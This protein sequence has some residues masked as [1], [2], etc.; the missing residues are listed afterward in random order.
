MPLGTV[1]LT[2]LLQLIIITIALN[3]E[4]QTVLYGFKIKPD[5]ELRYD[6]DGKLFPIIVF[7]PSAGKE[8]AQK[9]LNILFKEFKCKH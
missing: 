2:N 7:Y 5:F 9:A 1:S 8:S 3:P 4:L 6:S